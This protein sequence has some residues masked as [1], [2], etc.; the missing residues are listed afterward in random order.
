MTRERER[1]KG[2]TGLGEGKRGGPAAPRHDLRFDRRGRPQA[3]FLTTAATN[4]NNTNTIALSIHI[5]GPPAPPM[6]I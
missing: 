3:I 1:E 6:L 5:G 2:K 4:A